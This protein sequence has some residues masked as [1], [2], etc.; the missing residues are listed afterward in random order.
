[1]IVT[2]K[3]K[4]VFISEIRSP[5]LHSTSTHIMTES[6]LKGWKAKN[7][8]VYFLAICED[9]GQAEA[10]EEYFSKIVDKVFV[11]NSFYKQG[12][13]K[14]EKLIDMAICS[15]S[16]GKYRKEIE[17]KLLLD[18]Q[19]DVVVA[20]MPSYEALPYSR[21]VLSKLKD[22]PYYQYWSDP[23]A[24]SGLNPK[25]FGI[26]RYPFYLLEK[27]AYRFADEIVFGT[28]TIYDANRALYGLY[29]SKMR[30]VDVAYLDT[31]ESNCEK[32]PYNHFIYAGNYYSNL[33]NIIPLYEAFKEL[34]QEAVLDIYGSTDISLEETDNVHIHG[35]VTASELKEIESAYL[36]NVSLLNHNCIQ[37]PGKT[38][39]QTANNTNILVIADGEYKKQIVEYLNTYDRYVICDNKIK[40][41]VAAI[42][43]ILKSAPYVCTKEFKE[44]YSP[45]NISSEIIT[46]KRKT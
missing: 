16:L 17:N 40:D 7:R 6:L 36:N 4:I 45:D 27:R 12:A 13:N 29:K 9:K 26:K 21:V 19:F 39:Y 24:L 14:Y 34:K 31:G 33:R 23:I 32:K 30:Y 25:D 5:N 46:N 41:I 3:N 43:K 42:R 1:M 44:K 11:V 37:I 35:R 22:V 28:K 2:E 38:F 8:T 10:I 18:M 20:H 15:F